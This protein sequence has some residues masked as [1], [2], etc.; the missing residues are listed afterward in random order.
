MFSEFQFTAVLAVLGYT[1]N[2]SLRSSMEKVAFVISL[3][4]YLLGASDVM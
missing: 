1:D 3:K 4:N 2:K